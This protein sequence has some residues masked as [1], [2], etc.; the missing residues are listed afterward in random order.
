MVTAMSVG[1]LSV[2]RM[3]SR[4]AV[5]ATL[6]SSRPDGGKHSPEDESYTPVNIE[7]EPEDE[8]YTPDNAEHDPEDEL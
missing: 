5:S 6:E 4:H 1:G 3:L 7:H 8:S 2:G